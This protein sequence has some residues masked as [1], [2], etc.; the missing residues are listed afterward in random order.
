MGDMSGLEAR[1]AQ[2]LDLTEMPTN[3]MEMQNYII[4]A[5]QEF[6]KLPIEIKNKFDNSAEKYISEI[7]TKKWLDNMG[8]NQKP[9]KEEITIEKPIE[10]A[11]PNE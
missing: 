3:L 10:G 6:E 4:K 2:Y 1:T 9:I 5:T 8:I 7:G 11:E